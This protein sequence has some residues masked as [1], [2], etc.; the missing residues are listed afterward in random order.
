VERL[1]QEEFEQNVKHMGYPPSLIEQVGAACREVE[2]A[3]ARRIFPFDYEQQV[4]L[5]RRIKTEQ[6]PV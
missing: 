3:L 2:A 1:D 5:Y 4:E 6:H